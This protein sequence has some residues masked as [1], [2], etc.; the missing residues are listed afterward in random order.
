MLEVP[1]KPTQ[2]SYNY[3]FMSVSTADREDSPVMALLLQQFKDNIQD[4][5]SYTKTG[6]QTRTGTKHKVCSHRS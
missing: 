4:L 6:K 5:M 1:N 2:L 3:Y